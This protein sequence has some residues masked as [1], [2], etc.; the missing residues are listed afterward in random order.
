MRAKDSKYERGGSRVPITTP[1][2]ERKTTEMPKSQNSEKK[3]SGTQSET[4]RQDKGTPK[5]T[6][7]R[8]RPDSTPFPRNS[9][10]N[11]AAAG[12]KRRAKKKRDLEA[13]VRGFE[14]EYN[15]RAQR[16]KSSFPLDMQYDPFSGETTWERKNRK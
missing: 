12:K 15:D 1:T 10:R 14:K 4:L 6:T 5:Y 3:S 13:A 9:N 2:V 16:E 7:S 8:E 11:A